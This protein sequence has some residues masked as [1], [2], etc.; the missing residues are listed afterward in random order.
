MFFREE[1]FFQVLKVLWISTV[2]L[3]LGDT[4]LRQ[5]ATARKKVNCTFTFHKRPES[6]ESKGEQLIMLF[7]KHHLE[8]AFKGR[9]YPAFKFKAVMISFVCP[10]LLFSFQNLMCICEFLPLNFS[11][12]GTFEMISLIFGR[13]SMKNNYPSR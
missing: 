13:L 3:P 10:W 4:V 9:C 8:K 7:H 2:I 1:N 5:V 11:V 12:K 6:E